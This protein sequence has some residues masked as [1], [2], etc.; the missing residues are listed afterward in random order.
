MIDAP[1]RVLNKFEGRLITVARAAVRVSPP[2]SAAPFLVDKLTIPPGLTA[3]CLELLCSTLA[4]GCVQYLAR[5]GWREERFLR[6]GRSV[7]GR[8]WRRSP[9]DD[10]RLRFSRPALDFLVAITAG[11][12]GWSR[13]ADG[14]TP[15][16]ELLILLVYDAFRDSEAAIG[17]RDWPAFAASAL[18]RLVWPGDF[19]GQD[20]ALPDYSG[21]T[22]GL[23]GLILE[24]I[25]QR[26][27]DA[28]IAAQRGVQSLGDADAVRDTATTI[29]HTVNRFLPA[30]DGERRDLAAFLVRAAA[31]YCRDA[32]ID[33]IAGGMRV[34]RVRLAE[35][36]AALRQA[37][38]LPRVLERLA[39][40][41]RQARG[42]SYLDDG[43]P[44][45]QFFLSVWDD[46]GAPAALVR[47]RELLRQTIPLYA[48]APE[49]R[50]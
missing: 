28:W 26:L 17:W 23:G 35:R 47:A 7:A 9:L 5:L 46:A 43:Y 41:E 49:T 14:L 31:R 40:W 20:R 25:Q 37:A 19:V 6:D 13:P 10:R 32:T 1:P 50:P 12:K 4:H 16:D 21:W 48:P 15:A 39:G 3:G 11:A 45:A 24:A 22:T 27:A 18:C 42:V 36:Y 8:L 29:D 2:D 38:V 33:D 34:G 30:I 44:A